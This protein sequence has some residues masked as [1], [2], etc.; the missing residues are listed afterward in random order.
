MRKHPDKKVIEYLKFRFPIY[1]ADPDAFSNVYVR[2]HYSAMAYPMEVNENIQ[3]EIIFG[4]LPDK[5][6]HIICSS[7]LTRPKGISKCRV[8]LD[9]LFSLVILFFFGFFLYFYN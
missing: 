6:M 7:I 2:N 3:K 8:I 5:Y 4:P 1:I 9:F